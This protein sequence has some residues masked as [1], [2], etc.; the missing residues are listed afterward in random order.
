MTYETPKLIV[1]LF[2]VPQGEE[3]IEETTVTVTIKAIVVITFH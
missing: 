2:G 3:N 1:D